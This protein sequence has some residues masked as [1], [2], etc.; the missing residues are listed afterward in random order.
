M[1][2]AFREFCVDKLLL[3]SNAVNGYGIEVK[4]T[5]GRPRDG[6][7][8]EV[9]IYFNNRLTETMSSWQL[10]I[11]ALRIGAAIALLSLTT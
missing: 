7:T 5:A 3:D 8:D 1:G 6:V 9:N 10:E 4:K 11:S 2:R